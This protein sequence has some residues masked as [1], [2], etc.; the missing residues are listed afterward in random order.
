[1]SHRGASRAV[2]TGIA[3]DA[4]KAHATIELPRRQRYPVGTVLFCWSSSVPRT[5]F[6]WRGT[7]LSVSQAVLGVGRTRRSGIH[8]GGPCSRWLSICSSR[9]ERRCSGTLFDASYAIAKPGKQPSQRKMSLLMKRRG[10]AER[11]EGSS[12]LTRVNKIGLSIVVTPRRHRSMLFF[13]RSE[14]S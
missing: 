4:F 9:Q 7:S 6:S 10:I 13:C 11:S 5:S 3:N 8:C 2:D 12:S 1:M 14:R